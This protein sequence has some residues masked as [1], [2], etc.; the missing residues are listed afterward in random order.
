[1]KTLGIVAAS[2]VAIIAVAIIAYKTTYPT[3]T[4]RYRMT[5]EVEVDGQVRSG[6][7]VIEGRLVKQSSM[8]APVPRVRP[9]FSGEAVFV[10]LGNGRH[11]IA[12][13]ASDRGFDHDFAKYVVTAH[14]RL[15]GNDQDLVKYKASGTLGAGPPHLAR[16]ASANLCD[17]HGY[18]RS[19]DRDHRGPAGLRKIFGPG[20]KPP[21][22][23][24]EMTKEPVTR[25]IEQ[26]LPWLPYSKYLSGRSV[27]G[28]QEPHCLHGGDFREG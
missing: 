12:A 21:A 5:V 19:D 28:P 4:Y 13:L 24:I 18:Q 22:I 2:F 8:I 11:V 14:F 26:K 17:L 20:V 15:S 7:S 23:T 27:C 6:A 25:G 9:E 3:Y 1:M 16:T 10:D